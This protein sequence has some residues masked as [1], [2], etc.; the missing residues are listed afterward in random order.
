MSEPQLRRYRLLIVPGGNFESI[1]N[2]L[3]ATSTLNIHNAVHDGLN[4]LGICA[5]AFVASNST[6]HGLNLTAGARFGFY[7]AEAR[8]IRKTAVAV[9]D[10]SGHT[11]DQY[12]EDGTQLSGWGAVVHNYTHGTPAAVEGTFGKGWVILTGVHF[13]APASWRAGLNF[14]SPA[15]INNAQAATLIRAA[16]NGESLAHF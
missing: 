10:S 14:R 3:T 5:G 9:S 8:G 7:A 15:D 13:E 12:W 2:S 4:Y 11:L 6:H 1:G 16:L